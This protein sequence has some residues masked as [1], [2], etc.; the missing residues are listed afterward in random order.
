MILDVNLIRKDFPIL[1]RLVEGQP[2][3]YLD[4]AA[5]S[6]KPQCV[7]DALTR[8]YTH[9]NSNV[10]RGIHT[11]SEEATQ[12]YEGARQKVADFISAPSQRSVI[13]TR[14]ATEAINLVAHSWGRSHVG[15]GDEILLTEMEHHSNIIPW[16]LL[17]KDVGAKLRCIPITEEGLLDLT[18]LDALLTERTK[19]VAITHVSNVL[20]TINPVGAIIEAAHRRGARVLVDGAQSAPHMPVNVAAIDCDFFALSGHKMLGPTGIGVLYG[21]EELLK[22]MEPFLGG[23]E[24]I[25]EVWLDRATW[26]ELPWKFEAGTPAIADA[27]ALGA[28]IDYLNALGMDNVRQHEKEIT[29]YALEKLGALEGMT[30]YGPKDPNLRG[31]VVA[32][33]YAELHPHDL[34]TALNQAG[35]A[36]RAGH[37]CAQ[38]LMRRLGVVATARASFYIYNTAE[39]IDL[40]A[41]ALI[42]VA[43]FFGHG[44]RTAR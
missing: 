38:P 43:E 42:K 21:K 8:Y 29:A 7:I 41:R 9:Y 34:G 1:A 14:N 28:A 33:N 16:Q 18:Q 22:D 35:I 13:F 15:P 40:L 31:G 30:I 3:T 11:L 6:Q 36:I 4:S 25:R 26:N 2:L 20:G 27:I 44:V 39:E 32:F 19:L 17:A 23:G 37:H 5:T 12:G 24:M 10:H